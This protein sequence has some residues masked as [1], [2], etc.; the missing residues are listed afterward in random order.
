MKPDPWKYIRL[1]SPI[2]L[3]V[4]LIMFL[5]GCGDSAPN[6]TS[7]FPE[8]E[9]NTLAKSNTPT[10]SQAISGA[11]KIIDLPP[12]A[13]NTLQLIKSGGPFP[14]SK[15][16]SVF[17]N[18]EGLLPGKPSGYYHEYTV[19]TPGSPDRGARRIVIGSKA[20][21]YYTDDHYNSFKLIV[22]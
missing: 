20:E 5:A 8:F 21:Y 2:L 22:E 17:N 6:N 16:G 9:Q 12:E 3:V 1:I 7:G 18:Y 14:Y 19:I 15:D 11:I 4:C 13:Q 10:A